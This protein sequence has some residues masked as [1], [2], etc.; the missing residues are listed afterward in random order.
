[1]PGNFSFTPP[2]QSLGGAAAPVATFLYDG[3]GYALLPNVLC[4]SIQYHEGNDP[5]TARFSYVLSNSNLQSPFP[6]QFEQLWPLNLPDPNLVG[7]YIADPGDRIVV[8]MVLPDSSLNVLFDGFSRAPQADVSGEQQHAGFAAVGVAIRCWD[9]PIQGRVQRSA[10]PK[11]IVK[12]DGSADVATNLPTVFNPND[13]THPNGQPNCTQDNQ[14]TNESDPTSSYPV[15]IEANL[16]RTTDPR[17]FWTLSKCVRYILGVCNPPDSDD[18]QGDDDPYDPSQLDIQD[19]YKQFIT[20]PDFTALDDILDSRQPTPGNEYYDP[21]KPSSYTS[22]PII[23][24]EFD[25]TNFAWPDALERLLGYHGFGMRW[26]LT[27]DDNGQPVNSFAVYRKDAGATIAPKSLWMPAAGD[28]LDPTQPNVAELSAS[29]DYRNLANEYVVEMAPTRY[30][31][32]FILAPAFTPTAGD[33]MASNRSKYFKSNLTNASVLDRLKYRTYVFDECGDGHWDQGS[34]KWKT[35]SGD[36]TPIF[37]AQP[38]NDGSGKSVPTFVN[39]YRPGATRLLTDDGSGDRYKYQV[40]ISRDY[41]GPAPAVWDGKTGHWQ[42]VKSS[43]WSLLDDELGVEF[44][45]EDPEK[46]AIG[47]YTGP[48]AQEPGETLK[49]VTSI[50]NPGTNQTNKYFY[51]MLTTVVEGDQGSDVIAPHRYASPLA[52]TVRRRVEAGDH[53]RKDVLTQ[54]S[55]Y[56]GPLILAYYQAMIAA[57]AKKKDVVLP[58]FDKSGN[59][60]VR[61]DSPSAADHAAQLRAAHEFPPVPVSVALQGINLAYQVGDRIGSIRGR[62]VSLL[63]NAGAE[64]S[65]APSYPFVVSVSFGFLPAQTTHLQLTD[66]RLEPAPIESGHRSRS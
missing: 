64:Q 46:I 63:Q 39:R 40:S 36:F 25:C 44:T 3:Q 59:I 11:S 8:L 6:E 65:E 18:E 32:S 58:A 53:W 33:E 62:N 27:Q 2:G 61:D 19:T 13:A 66:R 16:D 31:A 14:D 10:D 26:T 55:I 50:A 48:N 60:V 9:I 52:N 51:V 23:V 38:L 41:D 49:G 15:F 35:T 56:Y 22:N 45:G 37:P 29:F 54:S 7:M 34:M 12:T 57:K 4:E 24:R 30:E 20:N 17:T 1:M 28:T 42:A 47:K 43:H 21:N 5:P